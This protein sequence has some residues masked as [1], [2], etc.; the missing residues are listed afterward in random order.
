MSPGE[1]TV[2]FACTLGIYWYLAE[3][4]REASHFIGTGA[5]FEVIG[6]SLQQPL[7]GLTSNRAL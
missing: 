7:P 1:F 6:I 3:V 5:G 2:S 4:M